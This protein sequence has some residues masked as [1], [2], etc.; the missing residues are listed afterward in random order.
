MP[1]NN[2]QGYTH[3]QEVSN[4]VLKMRENGKTQREISEYYGFYDQ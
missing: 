1:S 3:I 2:K 4:E